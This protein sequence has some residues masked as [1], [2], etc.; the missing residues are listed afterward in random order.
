KPV[1]QMVPMR[2]GPKLATDVY[3]PEGSGPWPVVLMRTP[4]GKNSQ[5]MAQLSAIN[6]WTR[7]GFAF[8]IQDCRGT[9]KSEGQYRPFMDDYLDGYDTVE[10]AAKQP[11]S[12]GHVGM[13]GASAMGI[14]AN[15]A[16]MAN[17]PHL[18]AAFVMV[19]RS[20]AYRQSSF[21]GGILRKEM[22]EGW[23]KLVKSERTLAETIK[24][25]DYDSWF[26]RAE[27]PKHWEQIHV[28]IY[29]YGGWYDI[30]N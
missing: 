25:Q 15:E 2:D 8:V 18:V 22:N 24:H 30:F 19:A 27:M 17:P 29:N 16:A 9:F 13:F 6:A 28:P 3:L 12:D 21:M 10:W 1:E 11:W 5:M 26:E 7:H 14:T 20:S 23:L 4:Y